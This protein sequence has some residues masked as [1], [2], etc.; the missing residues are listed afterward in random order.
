VLL[1][2]VVDLRS[3]ATDR[4]VTDLDRFRELII[5]TRLGV[6][7]RFELVVIL[8][9][10]FTVVAVSA[11][12]AALMIKFGLVFGPGQR[13]ELSIRARFGIRATCLS[14]TRSTTAFSP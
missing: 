5:I 4:I 11:L 1:I 6:E 3:I 12:G 10:R 13:L 7:F 8:A 14:G 2:A 9:I